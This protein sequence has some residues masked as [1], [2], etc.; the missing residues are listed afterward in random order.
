MTSDAFDLT[1]RPASYWD[2]D[3]LLRTPLA[4]VKGTL[5]RQ[6]IRDADDPELLGHLLNDPSDDERQALGRLHPAFMGGEYLPD[7]EEGEVE[8]ARVELR[9]VTGDVF[10]VRAR[11]EGSHIRYRIVD[12]YGSAFEFEPDASEAP[13]TLGQLVA[14]LDTAS[15][16]EWDG[17]RE[18]GLL[19]GFWQAQID[20]GGNAPEEAVRFATVTS[21]LSPMLADY[22][23]AR[24]R[25]WV[26][27]RSST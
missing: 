2:A 24:A 19:E 25:A 11:P 27:E 20:Y 22:Y 15:D 13:L 12:E 17:V 23:L 5:R 8:I 3:A 16:P 6:A 26:A 10:S 1:F 7:A 21:E 14:L 18:P 4:N 9:S